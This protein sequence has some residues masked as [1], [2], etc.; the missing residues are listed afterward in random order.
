MS[1]APA[2]RASSLTVVDAC[3]RTTRSRLP[4]VIFLVVLACAGGDAAAAS[5][6]GDHSC[7]SWGDL[8]YATKKNW[9]NAFLAPLSLT[10]QGLQRS[11]PDKYNSDPHAFE[12]AIVSIDGFCATHPDK[13]PADAAASY[14][15]TL[16]GN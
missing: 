9:T 11:G 6:F 13:G 16:V 5:L 15:N 12:A 10:H 14:L 7:K 3:V 8:D 2:H 4:S 1:G